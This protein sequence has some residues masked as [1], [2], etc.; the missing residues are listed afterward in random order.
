MQPGKT[1]DRGLEIIQGQQ[2]G[3]MSSLNPDSIQAAMTARAFDDNFIYIQLWYY[4]SQNIKP[5]MTP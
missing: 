5:T 4:V 2:E 3:A 1:F